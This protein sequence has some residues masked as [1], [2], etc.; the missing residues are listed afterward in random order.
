MCRA[1][2]STVSPKQNWG[3]L[4]GAKYICLKELNNKFITMRYLRL[5][6]TK[7][8]ALAMI[9]QLVFAGA[10][11]VYAANPIQDGINK[12]GE[13]F[14]QITGVKKTST[15]VDIILYAIRVLLYVAMAIDVFFIIIGGYQYIT[16]AGNEERAGKG[17]KTLVNAIIGLVIIIMSYTIVSVVNNQLTR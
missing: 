1:L 15:V 2:H 10:G 8:V 17:R 13:P 6:A 4:F 11:F 16:S 14:P 12:A 5:I 7:V 3:Q 9:A